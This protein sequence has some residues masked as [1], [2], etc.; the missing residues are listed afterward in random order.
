MARQ[1]ETGLS[2]EY[3]FTAVFQP[4]E[5]GGYTV[6]FPAVPNL[7]TQGETLEEA[8]AMALDCLQGYL[9]TLAERGLPLPEG[10]TDV[11]RTTIREAVKVRL[12]TA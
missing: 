2:A 8:R 5:E 3:T 6:S 9:E 10:E 1:N 11:G 4:A 7:A 12:K